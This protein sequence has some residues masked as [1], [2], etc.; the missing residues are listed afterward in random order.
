MSFL[1]RFFTACC[2]LCLLAACAGTGEKAV[3]RIR[4][5]NDQGVDGKRVM[6]PPPG[7]GEVARY[8][9]VG[10]LVGEANFVTAESKKDTFGGVLRWLAGILA[11]DDDAAIVLQRPQSGVVDEQGRILVTDTSRQ[12]VFVFDETQGKLEVWEKAFGLT[13][14]VSP[15]GIALGANG[16]VFVADSELGVVVR[17]DRLGNA[18]GVIGRD[19]LQRPTGVAYDPLRRRLYVADT[20]ESDIKVFD[21]NG[22]LISVFGERGDVAG[23]LN[24]PTYLALRGK[25]LY[26]SDTMNARVQVLSTETGKPLLTVSRRGQVVGDLV[27]PKGVALDGEGNIYVVESYHDHLLVYNRKGQFLMP[28]GGGAGVEVGK[29]FLPSGV[30]IDARNRIFLA[31]TFNGRIVVFQFLG[32]GEESD[33]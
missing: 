27:R 7:D 9:Y 1:T 4:A 29:Y 18:L 6:F 15:I 19:I 17:L 23:E 31:D 26:V 16:E 32:G 30:W 21:P 8:V 14:F 33:W 24:M 20:R 12:A 2:I 28:L 3:L 13:N 22:E 25:E 10:Q 11:G 5:G